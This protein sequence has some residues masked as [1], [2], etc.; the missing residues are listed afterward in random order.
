[1]TFRCAIGLARRGRIVARLTIG[2]PALLFHAPFLPTLEGLMKKTL[3]LIAAL[4]ATAAF[5]LAQKKA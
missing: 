5:S 2:R 3:T 1:V 4:A